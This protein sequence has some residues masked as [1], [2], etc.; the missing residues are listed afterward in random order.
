MGSHFLFKPSEQQ[1]LLTR[2][3]SYIV[4]EVPT[5]KESPW[6]HACFLNSCV[7]EV[8]QPFT[9]SSKFEEGREQIGI[10]SR[11]G[12]FGG[13][14]QLL[15]CPTDVEVPRQNNSS[16]VVFEVPTAKVSPWE[17]ACS[18]IPCVREVA[19]PLTG[20]WF[21]EGIGVRSEPKTSEKNGKNN[22]AERNFWGHGL[23]YC[24]PIGFLRWTASR[25]LTMRSGTQLCPKWKKGGSKLE[26]V[27]G[28]LFLVVQSTF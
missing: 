11:E 12:V 5:A 24:V 18:M 21:A 22:C 7:R 4:I 27:H 9:T 25:T 13:P 26:F 6:E 16:G 8:A 23:C 2:L 15:S 14:K 3:V 10:Y 28:K 19:Q 17:H 20:Q 1:C